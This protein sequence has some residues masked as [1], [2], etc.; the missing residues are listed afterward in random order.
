[1]LWCDSFMMEYPKKPRFLFE[2]G[3][4]KKMFENWREQLHRNV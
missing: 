1:M 4:N 2:R 3:N